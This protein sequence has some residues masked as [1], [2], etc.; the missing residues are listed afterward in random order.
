MD[1]AQ[2]DI[3]GLVER[4]N[5]AWTSGRPADIGRYVHDD[6]AIVG[7]DFSVLAQGRDACVG[8]YAE[9]CEQARTLA[10][11]MHDIAV[12]VIGDTA[13]AFYGFDIRYER[14]GSVSHETGREIFVFGWSPAGWLAV[15]RIIPD[16]PT[17]MPL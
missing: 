9:F 17:E 13:L 6:V 11:S 1:S 14:D 4:V 5:E 3:R 2:D 8:S 15:S 16:W 7:P 10:F 12:Q